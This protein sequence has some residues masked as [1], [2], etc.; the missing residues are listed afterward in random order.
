LP[1]KHRRKL[2]EVS[3]GARPPIIE[4]GG[5]R[6]PFAPQKSRWIFWK[7]WSYFRNKDKEL[8]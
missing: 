2:W 4:E 5:Q 3:P 7:Y 6:Y 8:K 1:N